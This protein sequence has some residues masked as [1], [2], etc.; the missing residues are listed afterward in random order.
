MCYN[1][2]YGN[3]PWSMCSSQKRYNFTLVT[4]WANCHKNF[5]DFLGNERIC[6]QRLFNKFVENWL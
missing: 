3:G 6:I 5:F 2:F 1:L 4:I